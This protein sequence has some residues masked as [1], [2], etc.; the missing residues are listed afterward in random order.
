MQ[1]LIQR[2]H[3]LTNYPESQTKADEVFCVTV[4][5]MLE[6]CSHTM[7]FKIYHCKSILVFY[8][9]DQEV[10]EGLIISII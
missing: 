8:K 9:L 5:S 2:K 1:E 6:L 3:E 10:G 7:Y 4:K